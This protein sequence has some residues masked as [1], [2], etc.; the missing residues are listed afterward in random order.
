M[1]TLRAIGRKLFPKQYMTFTGEDGSMNLRHGKV[2][3]VKIRV[4]NLIFSRTSYIWVV[5]KPEVESGA[6]HEPPCACP[7]GSVEALAKN[8]RL[9]RKGDEL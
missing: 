3:Q 1:K 7:Y 4:E 2:Y 9:P 5:W 8:W 6:T